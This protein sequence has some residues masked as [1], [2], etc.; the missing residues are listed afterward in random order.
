MQLQ[1]WIVQNWIYRITNGTLARVI[2]LLAALMGFVVIAFLYDMHTYTDLQNQEGMETAQLARNLAFGKGYTTQTIRPV[3]IHLLDKH[4]VGSSAKLISHSVPDI[5][6]PPAYP[7]LM[8]GVFKAATLFQPKGKMP[9]THVLE[10]WILGLNQGLFFIAA[11][12]LFVLAKE[13]FDSSVAWLSASLFV[14]T[15]LYWQFTIAGLPTFLLI[16][17]F[18]AATWGLVRMLKCN[19]APPSPSSDLACLKLA[20]LAGL[21]VGAGAL[22]RYAFVFLAVPITVFIL[23]LFHRNR[24]KLTL[25]FLLA[26][27]IVMGPWLSRNYML[28]DTLFGSS[29]YAIFQQTPPFPEDTLERSLDIKL[30]LNRMEPG[31]YV[32]K[33]MSNTHAILGVDFALL[34][35]SWISCFFLAGILIP[36]KNKNLSNLRLYLLGCLTLFLAVQ[37]LGQTHLSTENPRINS[38]NLLVV[39]APLAFMFGTALFFTLLDQLT[40]EG[41]GS[42]GIVIGAF[43]F[44]ISLPFIFVFL[45]PTAYPDK[46]PY[47]SY[48]IQR[49]CA[50]LSEKENMISDIPFAVAWHGN[51]SCIWLPLD[52]KNK[53]AQLNAIKP[54]KGIYLTQKTTD[55]EVS[56][57]AQNP[58]SWERFALEAW[59]R[60]EVP[61]KFPLTHAPIGFMPNRIFI[62][63]RERWKTIVK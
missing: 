11:L 21:M 4:I 56:Q 50:W 2:R 12:L 14:L 23:A 18:L 52:D 38:E 9:S 31:F 58:V 53:F 15:D 1:N 45:S 60:G 51:R 8:S 10:K 22:T 27:V 3:D 34:G 42:R 35:G 24:A 33:L 59:A 43:G 57:K 20:I 41:F 5:S 46:N 28:T 36:F 55:G 48:Y 26:I 44:L 47:S 30:G 62:S 40:F 54:I 49:V 39:L 19:N 6:T 16:I 29:G 61:D 32:D 13:M 25:G 7:I 17:F 63:D 37:A